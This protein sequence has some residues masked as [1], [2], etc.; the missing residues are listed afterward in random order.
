MVEVCRAPRS[1]GTLVAFAVSESVR[2]TRVYF[3]ENF[4][5]PWAVS[6]RD[7]NLLKLEAGFRSIVQSTRASGCSPARPKNT[8]WFRRS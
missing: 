7:H 5:R 6:Q 2:I 8:R 1:S 4:Q 3:A